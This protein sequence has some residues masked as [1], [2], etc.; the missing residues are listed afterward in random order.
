MC[1]KTHRK[2]TR[3]MAERSELYH[4]TTSTHTQ[5]TH[6]LQTDIDNKEIELLLAFAELESNA[7]DV[8]ETLTCA[9]GTVYHLQ[10]EHKMQYR[11]VTSR[12]FDPNN[13]IRNPTPRIEQILD[14]VFVS[15]RTDM[16]LTLSGE[17]IYINVE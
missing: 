9:D 8:P 3:I 4:K 1:C 10:E 11:Y 12:L 14:E 15:T 16:L 2:I 5:S 6:K 7:P 13:V 17:D